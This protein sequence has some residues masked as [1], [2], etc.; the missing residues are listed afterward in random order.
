M[1]ATTGVL[2][3]TPTQLPGVYSATVR[4]SNGVAP[5]AMQTFSITLNP[6]PT[7]Q[8]ISPVLECVVDRGSSFIP[9][10]IA[11]FGYNNP[12]A[13]AVERVVGSANR[14]SPVPQNRGQ[15]TVF[16]PGRQQFTFNVPFI[17]GN[18]VWTLNG[19]TATASTSDRSLVLAGTAEP[20]ST[21]MVTQVGVGRDRHGHGQRAG[22]WSFNYGST[23]LADGSHSFTA[24][25]TD[26]AGNA[27][28]S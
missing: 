27:S 11:R 14:F 24:T 18:Q 8:P 2:A 10:Y 21:V 23:R 7:V 5:A 22:A 3:W 4:A 28:T 15:T 9:R 13:F 20:L 6:A 26:A 19:R 1:N 12:N 16:L 17:G 25:V